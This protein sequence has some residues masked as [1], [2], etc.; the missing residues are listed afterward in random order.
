[1]GKYIDANPDNIKL[2]EEKYNKKK[3]A[4]KE[5]ANKRA[6]DLISIIN[7]F[8]THDL[9]SI[10]DEIDKKAKSNYYREPDGELLRQAVIKSL[11]N[12]YTEEDITALSLGREVKRIIDSLPIEDK[13]QL[14]QEHREY[15]YRKFINENRKDAR[16]KS[17]IYSMMSNEEE[18]KLINLYYNQCYNRALVSSKMMAIKETSKDLGFKTPDFQDNLLLQKE[19]VK[20]ADVKKQPQN[21]NELKSAIKNNLR[22]A[23]DTLYENA[24]LVFL[25][26]AVGI[27]SGGAISILTYMSTLD[28]N[29]PVAAFLTSTPL[30][31]SGLVGLY[32]SQDIADFIKEKKELKTAREFG[33]VDT[34]AKHAKSLNDLVN[35]EE[36]LKNKYCKIKIERGIKQ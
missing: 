2:V 16:E 23:A 32:K 33:L 35:Y 13:K 4:A 22:N 1:M 19:S 20:I 25:T 21:I 9:K 15:K 3:I 27:T 36:E 7:Y 18:N 8:K 10:Y 12:H 26:G 11:E 17:A 28:E 34:M 29:L 24:N 14:I 31:I 6:N 30:I 5:V